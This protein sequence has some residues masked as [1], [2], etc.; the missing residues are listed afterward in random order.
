M[1]IAHRVGD[2]GVSAAVSI[3]VD[4][5]VDGVTAR[6]MRQAVSSLRLRRGQFADLYSPEGVNGE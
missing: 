4:A 6:R 3:G 2:L 5:G 1:R